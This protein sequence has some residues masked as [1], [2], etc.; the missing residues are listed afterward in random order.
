MKR[1][2][3]KAALFVGLASCGPLSEGR[4]V[5]QVRDLAAQ[6]IAARAAAETATDAAQGAGLTRAVIEEA[7]GNLMRLT[8]LAID[9]TDV[10]G[11]GGR[12][13]T[14]VTWLSREG[15]SFTFDEG[16][17]VAS[18]RTGD[19]LMGADVSGAKRSLRGGGTH[20]R[21]HDYLDGLDQIQQVTFRCESAVVRQETITIFERSYQTSVIDETCSSEDLEFKNTYWRDGTGVVWQSRQWISEPIGYLS[22]QR[23]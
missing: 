4:S 3:M 14:K 21:V 16:L 15:F 23:L 7:P 9:A 19:D 11:E 22:Y 8:I 1:I 13:G 2:W 18:R 17:L 6:L 10:L 5:A 12:N 20:S